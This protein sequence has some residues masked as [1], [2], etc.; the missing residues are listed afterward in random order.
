MSYGESVFQQQMGGK[1]QICGYT[2]V[3]S[4]LL[5]IIVVIIAIIIKIHFKK[6]I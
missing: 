3:F 2:G 6:H 5:T 1:R 4:A